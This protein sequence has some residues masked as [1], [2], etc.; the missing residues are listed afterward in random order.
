MR[1]SKLTRR[2]L[3]RSSKKNSE[4]SMPPSS[5]TNIT[6]CTTGK[7]VNTSIIEKET[8][9]K[10]PNLATPTKPETISKPEECFTFQ[11]DDEDED[12]DDDN[13]RRTIRKSVKL[14]RPTSRHNISTSTEP[15]NFF[16]PPQEVTIDHLF[17]PPSPMKEPSMTNSQNERLL[18]DHSGLHL[19]FQN[20]H[21]EILETQHHCFGDPVGDIAMQ[22]QLL[23]AQRLVRVILEPSH[24]DQQLLDANTIL[25]AIRSHA[26]MKQELIELR[27]KQET[28]DGDPPCILQNIGSPTAT[29]PSTTRTRHRSVL[30]ADGICAL[31]TIDDVPIH[32][33]STHE[34]TTSTIERLQQ[35]LASADDTILKLQ[36]EMRK[37]YDHK[38]IAKDGRKSTICNEENENENSTE[39]CVSIEEQS[40]IK[41]Q[42][43]QHYITHQKYTELNV[44]YQQLVKNHEANLE[45][46]KRN[47]DNV[48]E[49]IACVPKQ[50]LVKESVR[51][52]LKLYCKSVTQHAAEIQMTK[53]E[54]MMRISRDESERR[55]QELE[56]RLRLQ[57]E[58]HKREIR[59][60]M[61]NDTKEN[62]KIQIKI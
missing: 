55:I 50:V 6:S 58:H 48:L 34:N 57:E 42:Q 38:N 16:H 2:S 60:T 52:K 62:Q 11:D 33:N 21:E 22:R 27:K 29:T 31:S 41:D 20:T 39:T 53:M 49:E 40:T 9:K 18:D 15:K 37:M 46:S 12:D 51:E 59:A 32:S 7:S 8:K 10:K 24:G 5:P 44:K 35:Q 56:S 3:T 26:L 28:I 4:N 17:V 1:L 54:E 19:N 14:P 30:S 43:D 45:E 13:Y 61:D 25:H 47:L 23:D 36:K